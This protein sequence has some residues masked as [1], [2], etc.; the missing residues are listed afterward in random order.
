MNQTLAGITIRSA[1]NA[2]RDRV[3][4]LIFGV[5]AEYGLAPDSQTTDADLEDI[6]SSYVKGGV[7]VDQL[8]G[9][10]IDHTQCDLAQQFWFKT[11]SS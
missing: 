8:T 2:D 1:T 10:K 3:K 7:K 6:E 11:G 9:A 4:E 5:L